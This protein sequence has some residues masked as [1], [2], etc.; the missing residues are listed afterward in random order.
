MPHSSL[1]TFHPC[2]S[3]SFISCTNCFTR[4]LTSK[5]V[6]CVHFSFPLNHV[7]FLLFHF[8][9]FYWSIVDL[10]WFDN[11]CWVTK[12]FSYTHIYFKYIHIYM[13]R[14]N[15]AMFF[16]SVYYTQ[17][18]IS[19]CIGKAGVLPT[20]RSSVYIK[21]PIWWQ[22]E[23]HKTIP[24]TRNDDENYERFCFLLLPARTCQQ[25]SMFSKNISFLYHLLF[26]A[27][28]W[29]L[30]GMYESSTWAQWWT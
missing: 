10:Q 12:W 4:P 9:K 15:H 30:T 22:G 27:S 29:S 13:E 24:L 19:P 26:G 5:L 2:T 16:Y 7:D 8:V 17:I 11:F 1:I 3:K 6:F 18:I 21:A 28:P 23:K 14:V 25:W 20:D